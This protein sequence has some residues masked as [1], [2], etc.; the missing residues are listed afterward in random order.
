MTVTAVCSPLHEDPAVR[1]DC[2][3][4]AHVPP[5]PFTATAAIDVE[6][7]LISS[8]VFAAPLPDELLPEFDDP[9][10]PEFDDPLLP[11]LDEPLLLDERPV[12]VG[13]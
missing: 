7:T 2:G 1:P 11:E 9:L 13:G 4:V 12:H 6:S 8:F 10:L 3:A 5:T